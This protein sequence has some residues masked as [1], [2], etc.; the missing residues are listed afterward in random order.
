MHDDTLWY[1]DVQALFMLQVM[2]CAAECD[3]KL[4]EAAYLTLTSIF[5]GLHCYLSAVCCLC[6]W[7]LCL[8]SMELSTCTTTNSQIWPIYISF[9][10]MCCLFFGKQTWTQRQ[11]RAGLQRLPWRGVAMTHLPHTHPHVT[12][13]PLNT[14]WLLCYIIIPAADCINKAP[15]HRHRRS[16]HTGSPCPHPLCVL[17][18]L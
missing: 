2:S 5:K 14:N 12:G 16:E 6:R 11:D 15:T 7:R 1:C 13:F 10:S 3:P 17:N 8:L 4:P 9:L 18:S